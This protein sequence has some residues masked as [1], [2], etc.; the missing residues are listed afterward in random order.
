MKITRRNLA[1]GCRSLVLLLITAL[2]G[3]ASSPAQHTDKLNSK[4]AADLYAQ[5]R[6]AL[7][8]QDYAQAGKSFKLLEVNYPD[9]PYNHQAQMELAYAY[10]KSA[11]YSSAIATA[12]RI[13]R[14]FP[15]NPNLDYARY[16][17]A[18]ASFEQASDLIE[19]EGDTDAAILAAKTSLGYFNDLAQHHPDS[20]YQQD[21]DK[22][23]AYLQEQLARYEVAAARRDIEKGNH[24][25]AVIHARNVVENYPQTHSAA[26]ALAIADM[27]Y[28]M[29]SIDSASSKQAAG[30]QDTSNGEQAAATAPGAGA[31]AASTGMTTTTN[32]GGMEPAAA[33]QQASMSSSSDSGAVAS[34]ADSGVT[35]A[36]NSAGGRLEGARPTSWILQQPADQYTIQLISTQKDA[37]LQHFIAANHLDGKTAYF[38]KRVKGRTWHSLIYGVYTD[39]ASARSAMSQ[40]PEPV[41]RSKPWILKIGSVQKAINAFNTTP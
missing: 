11:D 23:V 2:A 1:F 40:L 4:A 14:N 31:S 32:G 20:K 13:I 24:A 6:K 21:A 34:D 33:P 19:K 8:A 16:L 5:G 9:S 36:T 27:G 28:E 15:D 25:S 26:D 37:T 22:R 10:F 17:K 38:R 30:K 35:S 29:M 3:C 39:T 12:D 41:R 18:L 7:Q